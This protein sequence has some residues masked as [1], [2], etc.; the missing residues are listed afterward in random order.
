LLY[1]STR[2][3]GNNPKVI[4]GDRV[5]TREEWFQEAEKA[6]RERAQLPFEEKIRILVKLQ[7]FARDWGRRPD[8]IVWQI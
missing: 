5:F 4:L 8:I 6:R 1:K 3:D 7:R 2:T